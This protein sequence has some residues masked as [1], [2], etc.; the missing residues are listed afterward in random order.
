MAEFFDR[1]IRMT[2][3]ELVDEI[4]LAFR[5]VKL[6]DGIGLWEGQGLDDYADKK[7]ILKLREKDE[8]ENW[9]KI[10][11]EDLERCE[12]SLC[13]FDAK[14]MRFHLPRFMIYELTK[15]DACD[16]HWGYCL[17]NGVSGDEY[18]VKQFSLLSR[19]QI[20]CIAHFIEFCRM[21]RIIEQD[22]EWD[23]QHG[24]SAD[25]LSDNEYPKTKGLLEKWKEKLNQIA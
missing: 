24:L 10:P 22:E 4:H 19:P 5:D 1:I 12:S 25:S 6:E 3:Q 9:D 2:K 23:K 7:T 21:P 13:F 18:S 11:F 17:E 14:G 20:A 15:P 16:I 8:K